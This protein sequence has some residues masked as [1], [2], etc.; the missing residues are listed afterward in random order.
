VKQYVLVLIWTL[1]Y[2]CAVTTL[3]PHQSSWTQQCPCTH[4][5]RSPDS[6][7]STRPVTQTLIQRMLLKSVMTTN[8]GLGILPARMAQRSRADASRNHD[9]HQIRSMDRC[10]ARNSLD[11]TQVCPPILLYRKQQ[12]PKNTTKMAPAARPPTHGATPKFSLSSQVLL[13]ARWQSLAA[14]LV[15]DMDLRSAP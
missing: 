1:V 11:A 8:T 7:S 14:Q 6:F 10:P 5:R 15:M 9:G 3:L 4:R 13:P 12:R 2:G